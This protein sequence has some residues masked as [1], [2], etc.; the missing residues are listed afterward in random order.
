MSTIVC[1]GI[2]TKRRTRIYYREQLLGNSI[3]IMAATPP[4]IYARL[5]QSR[6]ECRLCESLG[7]TNPAACEGGIYD[8]DNLGPW[9]SW[10]G[11]LNP[12]L[13]IIGQDWGDTK[14]YRKQRGIEDPNSATN[15]KLT[16]LVG[17][18][19]LDMDSVFLTNAVL[20][21]KEGGAQAPVRQEW[22]R[23]CGEQFLKR[24]IEIVNPRVLVTLGEC[25]FWS[26]RELFQLPRISFRK[27]VDKVDGFNLPDR[28]RLFPVYHCSCRILNTHRPLAQP[29]K[30]WAR[31]KR[32]VSD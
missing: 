3:G 28:K 21:L 20:C 5:V 31:I 16:Y 14:C 2:R 11:K 18:I 32:A 26:L 10:H 8:S 30:D 13:M 19:G 25:S 23:N 29:E 7:L 17:L 22:F 24:T 4:D 9:S 1:R 15:K 6:K 12:R 27:A